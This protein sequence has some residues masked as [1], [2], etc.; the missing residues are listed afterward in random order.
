MLDWL[1]YIKQTVFIGASFFY[2]C[3]HLIGRN[4]F[5]LLE[6]AS[7]QY[8][9]SYFIGSADSQYPTFQL[10]LLQNFIC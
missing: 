7:Q 10:Y 3:S 8:S 5:Y 9:S 2:Y 6:K 1:S 4:R